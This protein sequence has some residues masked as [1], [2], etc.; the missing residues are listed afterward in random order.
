MIKN[1]QDKSFTQSQDKESHD[2]NTCKKGGCDECVDQIQY[3]SPITERR[4]EATARAAKKPQLYREKSS[5]D[6]EGSQR[7]QSYSN[8][9]KR[10]SKYATKSS[11][12]TNSQ[13]TP[14]LKF[15][16]FK[17]GK[18]Y[19]RISNGSTV[20]KLPQLKA[21]MQ[22]RPKSFLESANVQPIKGFDQRY[23]FAESRVQP[24]NM[25]STSSQKTEAP[26]DSQPEA[27]KDSKPQPEAPK[28]PKPEAPQVPKK[29][30]PPFVHEKT[31]PT[32]D[33]EALFETG[34]IPDDYKLKAR[35]PRTAD[36]Q[37]TDNG[38]KLRVYPE[39]APACNRF[40]DDI[41]FIVE[42]HMFKHQEFPIE[43]DR[44]A[45]VYCIPNVDT[46]KFL[47]PAAQHVD[48]FIPLDQQPAKFSE[49][50][51]I[52]AHVIQMPKKL[53]EDSLL[54]FHSVKA[55]GSINQYLTKKIVP[56]EER[57]IMTCP[58]HTD[59]DYSMYPYIWSDATA[60]GHHPL[61]GTHLNQIYVPDWTKINAQ[62]KKPLLRVCVCLI[63]QG[64]VSM[65][66]KLFTSKVFVTIETGA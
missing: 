18:P 24:Q 66:C 10:E 34:I 22:Q 25:P 50:K 5:S 11:T 57:T 29:E 64:R 51:P 47:S 2:R 61:P 53:M 55:K 44:D 35:K 8:L 48:T 33:L 45:K 42:V 17:C 39:N 49:M 15:P 63:C 58:E 21:N 7:Q 1:P 37:L 52:D 14:E 13:P 12:K 19:K 9:K 43:S 23:S 38:L 62:N 3:Q 4:R 6:D 36:L 59:Y 65:E 32:K 16:S 30:F 54:E 27:P 40:E 41:E 31:E 28:V 60:G 26:K 46:M 20:Y 56:F